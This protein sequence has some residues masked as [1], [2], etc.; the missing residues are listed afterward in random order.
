M[1]LYEKQ[2]AKIS[3]DGE[4]LRNNNTTVI[5]A[6]CIED[7]RRTIEQVKETS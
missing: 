2:T 3:L 7:H 1:S 5:L 4:Q 6:D